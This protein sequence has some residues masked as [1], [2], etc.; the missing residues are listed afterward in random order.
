M[1][2]HTVN[3]HPDMKAKKKKAQCKVS[4]ACPTLNWCK[5]TKARSIR[6][7]LH[8]GYKIQQ[9]HKCTKENARHWLKVL[10]YISKGT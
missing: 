2:I 7:K 6:F 9:G 3:E 10:S 5:N 1:K 4:F 8:Q